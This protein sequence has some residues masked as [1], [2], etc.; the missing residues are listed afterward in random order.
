[1]ASADVFGTCTWTSRH[2]TSADRAPTVLRN[3]SPVLASGDTPGTKRPEGKQ[4]TAQFRDD[5]SARILVDRTPPRF[6]IPDVSHRLL[7][8]VARHL[9]STLPERAVRAG[10]S[11]RAAKLPPSRAARSMTAMRA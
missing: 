9:A 6:L 4:P 10:V 1:M 3:E 8:A 7:V 11:S 5:S 2:C